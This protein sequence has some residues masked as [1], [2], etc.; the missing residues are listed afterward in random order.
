[1][2]DLIE[3]LRAVRESEA[4][5]ARVI[6]AVEHATPADLAAPSALPGWSR[7]HVLAHIDGIGRALA[8]QLDHAARG[9]LID[10]YDGGQAGRDAVIEAGAT[11]TRGEHL[12]ALT[13]LQG[14]LQEAWPEE[15]SLVWFTPVRY[16]DGIVMDLALAWWREISIHQVDLGLGIDAAEVWS[17]PLC[18]YLLD[19]LSVRLPSGPLVE[20]DAFEPGVRYVVAADSDATPTAPVT[21]TGPLTSI[22]GWLAGREIHP[23]PIATSDEDAVDLPEL[24]PWP[25]R[26]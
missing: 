25:S 12:E 26:R 3:P 21:V 23:L 2:T 16:R 4:A 11:R 18:E 17:Q 24:G 7:G 6:S 22:A 8:R 9:Q 1:M 10:V 20:L 5:L 15:D 13:A 14:Q 19:F